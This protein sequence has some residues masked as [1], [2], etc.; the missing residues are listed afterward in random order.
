MSGP[1][2]FLEAYVFGPG[3]SMPGPY[4]FLQAYGF[5]PGKHTLNNRCLDPTEFLRPIDL[6]PAKIRYTMYA[7][8]YRDSRVLTNW[9]RQQYAWTLWVSAGLWVWAR[10]TYSKQQ[11][12]GPYGILEA[13]SLG[14]GKNTLN[15][16]CLDPMGFLRPVG[17]H[18][19][20]VCLDPMS[21][22]RPMGL[23]P[24]NIL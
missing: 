3:N 17:L 21:F 20:T 5:G 7:V 19:A 1:Y 13:Y 8:S 18:P 14:S 9:T 16:G 11:M 24:A 10:Q 6:D 12:S 22:C 23:V 4:G 15:S 2:G